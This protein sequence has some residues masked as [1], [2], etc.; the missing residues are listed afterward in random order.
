MF[1]RYGKDYVEICAD[2]GGMAEEAALAEEAIADMD[3][4][5]FGCRLGRRVVPACIR[6]IIVNKIGSKECEDGTDLH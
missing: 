5:S 4:N 6:C 1:V 2:T 3:E